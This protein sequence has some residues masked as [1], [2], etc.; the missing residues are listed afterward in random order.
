MNHRGLVSVRVFLHVCV[1]VC[2]DDLEEGAQIVFSV[3]TVGLD[4]VRWPFGCFTKVQQQAKQP[5]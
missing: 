3:H 4:D 2:Q 1:C 5:V